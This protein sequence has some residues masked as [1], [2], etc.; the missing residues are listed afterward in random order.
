MAEGALAKFGTT[1]S[2]SVT[3]IAGPGGGSKQKPVGTVWIALAQKDKSTIA[4][5]FR[6]AGDRA[7]I[8]ERSADSALEM[9]RRKQLG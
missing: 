2:L 7:I 1:Y 9:L 8:R 6:Y 5:S 4:K 3:G